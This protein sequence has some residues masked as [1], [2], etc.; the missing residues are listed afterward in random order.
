MVEG[1]EVVGRHKHGGQAAGGNV[2]GGGQAGR[3]R[4]GGKGTGVW[5]FIPQC[6]L[7]YHNNGRMNIRQ[8]STNYS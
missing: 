2:A 1:Q 5:L 7:P 4:G 6:C 3:A 8:L